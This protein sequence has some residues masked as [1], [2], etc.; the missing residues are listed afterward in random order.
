M[1]KAILVV[2]FGTTY[3]HSRKNTIDAIENK[4][5]QEFTD[6]VVE[7]AFTSNIVIKKLND[8]GIK[9]NNVSQALE[10]L[11]D[12]DEIII[13]PTHIIPGFEYEKII[14]MAKDF[15]NSENKNIVIA[16][17]L[18]Y[19][20]EDYENMAQ[21][22]DNTFGDYRGNVIF[23][24]HGSSHSS[25]SAYEKLQSEIKNENIFIATVEGKVS[26]DSIINKVEY[27]NV[28]LTPLMVVSGDHA[29]N[30][31]IE[32]KDLLSKKGYD[33]ELCLKGLG[34]YEQIRNMY[35]Q[36]IRNVEK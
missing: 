7:S 19:N 31:L 3:D 2:S 25:D 16:D 15:K 17:T 23:M 11:V 18:L 27:S 29:N 24:G 12:C 28:L 9:V 6:Y 35:V 1:K 4:I 10:K 32:W 22:I 13:Q 30:D 33:V 26:I 21:F 34:E 14:K 8:R 5:R 20:K 36:H